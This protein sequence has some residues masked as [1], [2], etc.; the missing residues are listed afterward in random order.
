MLSSRWI[1]EFSF[2]HIMSEICNGPN[3][4]LR[5]AYVDGRCPLEFALV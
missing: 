3:L 5:A 4:I 1:L 2:V